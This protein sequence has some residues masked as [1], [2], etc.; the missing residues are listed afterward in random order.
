MHSASYFISPNDLW[1]LIGTAQAPQ[2]V[3]TRRRDV[4]DAAPG[5]AADRIVARH[6]RHRRNGSRRSTATVRS[7]SPARP[8]HEMSQMPA[9]RS[10]RREAIDARVLAGGYAA[11]TEAKLP[12]VNKAALDRFAPNGRAC[13]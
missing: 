9:A 6:R 4:Y 11:W 5:R 13:G 1:N 8:R 10:A 12:L 7:C 2:I 3:D